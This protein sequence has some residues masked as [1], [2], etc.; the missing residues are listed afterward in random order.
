MQKNNKKEVITYLKQ[1][2]TDSIKL[3][4][5]SSDAYA[6]TLISKYPLLAVCNAPIYTAIKHS[7]VFYQI[8]IKEPVYL[9]KEVCENLLK[10][11]VFVN[12]IKK[13]SYSL[14]LHLK[15]KS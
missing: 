7:Q 1:L 14:F 12:Y 10:N 6:D 11:K 15:N 13:K 2:E 4:K 9:S 3:A 8:M 5:I